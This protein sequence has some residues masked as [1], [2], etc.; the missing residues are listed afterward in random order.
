MPNARR[1]GFLPCARPFPLMALGLRVFAAVIATAV[2]RGMQKYVTCG[3]RAGF[4]DPR[5]L[6][7]I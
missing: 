3:H 1:G 7:E 2:E 5:V 6:A 4:R